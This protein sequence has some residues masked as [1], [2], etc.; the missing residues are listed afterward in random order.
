MT[1]EQEILQVINQIIPTIEKAFHDAFI[2]RHPG[3]PNQKT[4][5]NRFGGYAATKESLRRLKDDK[6]ARERY[7]ET[8]RK[9]AA[10]G[11]GTQTIS[12]SGDFEKYRGKKIKEIEG[13]KDPKRQ[14]LELNKLEQAQEAFYKESRRQTGSAPMMGKQEIASLMLNALD[15]LDNPSVPDEEFYKWQKI[16]DSRDTLGQPLGVR[17]SI[18]K[19]TPSDGPGENTKYGKRWT[20]RLDKY[21]R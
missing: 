21:Y 10:G 20:K 2:L 16:A 13:I 8:A 3:H 19:H 5:G 7:K 11:G 6:G 15:R 4:H 1:L 18:P 17:F 9:R 14:I 12:N